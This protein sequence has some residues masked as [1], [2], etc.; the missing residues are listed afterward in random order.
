MQCTYK[1]TMVTLSP[2]YCCCGEGIMHSV[3]I[4][5]LGVTANNVKT[6]SIVQ[7]LFYG[8][9]MLLATMKHRSYCCELSVVFVRT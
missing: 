1:A 3:C 9:F 7:K 2:N 6:W 4:V 8:E 5:G